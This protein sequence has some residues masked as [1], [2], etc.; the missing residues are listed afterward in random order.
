V[1]I[2]GRPP[3][4]P[5]D[6]GDGLP[7]YVVEV[8]DFRVPD[9]NKVFSLFTAVHSAEPCGREAYVR[10]PEDLAI[11]AQGGAS[12]DNGDLPGRPKTSIKAGD[13]LKREKLIFLYNSP[14]GWRSG[15]QDPPNM[16]AEQQSNSRPPAQSQYGGPRFTYSEE[17]G[18]GLNTNRMAPA[19]GWNFRQQPPYPPPGQNPVMTEPEGIAT[20]NYVNLVMR[21]RGGRPLEGSLDIHGTVPTAQVF[22]AD[23]VADPRQNALSLEQ[24]QRMSA[25]MNKSLNDLAGGV[26]V[27]G[28]LNSNAP[29]AYAQWTSTGTS[30]DTINYATSG[31]QMTWLSQLGTVSAL[32]EN[33][34]LPGVNSAYTPATH[35]VFIDSARAAIRTFTVQ[36]LVG[37]GEHPRLDTEG[38][39]GYV[40]NPR[41]LTN[42][43]N[44][45][46]PP[47]D[48]PNNPYFPHGF[49]QVPYAASSMQMFRDY[50][51]FAT[52][53]LVPVNP[54]QVATGEA[55][56]HLDT[57]VVA[58]TALPSDATGA[59]VTPQ[60]YYANL[61]HFVEAGGNLVLTDRAVEALREMNLVGADAIKAGTA[62]VGYIDV[63]DHNSEL[64]K[65]RNSLEHQTYDPI[66]LGYQIRIE[67]DGHWRGQPE[68][69]SHNM[70]P[71]WMID[72]SA[73][74]KA[75]GKT[76][77][78]SDPL[79]NPTATTDEGT[80]TDKV[81]LGTL[82]LGKGRIVFIGA[83]LPDP[84]DQYPHWFGL[85]GYAP[86]ALG[87][88]LFQKAI[89]WSRGAAGVVGPVPPA[90]GT[91]GAALPTTS[92]SHPPALP[93]LLAI[94][95]LAALGL[96][97]RAKRRRHQP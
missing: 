51:T 81:A 48:F 56:D 94:F 12:W 62:Y 35:K 95:A 92:R 10:T 93:P 5:G 24:V 34:C 8:T 44:P 45:S 14:D 55:L 57:L 53:P 54:G 49:T 33:N 59:S 64:T 42:L 3:W 19:I 86:T 20:W 41:R 82:I 96:L 85:D 83:L 52:R 67:R 18:R 30:F 15:D 23:S 77:A 9:T 17:N 79:N 61:R 91:A 71:I 32:I 90:A 11:A 58:N 65:G 76:I 1:G 80:A 60:R 73:W 40:F 69:G 26:D 72:R 50:S 31:D 28:T 22:S 75:G 2:D 36:T 21:Q 68:S 29:T 43:D 27:A 7:I 70:A 63:Q 84:T 66:S 74:E 88:H 97:A 47:L 39:V 46:P 89:T 87:H 16:L 38:T 4:D 6:S 37:Q 13:L 25:S 78:T